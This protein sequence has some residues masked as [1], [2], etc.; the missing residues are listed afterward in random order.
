[1]AP[2]NVLKERAA[3]R[4]KE[5][6]EENLAVSKLFKHIHTGGAFTPRM[7]KKLSETDQASLDLR[8]KI[9]KLRNLLYK[10]V[11]LRDATERT[12]ALDGDPE[13]VARRVLERHFPGRVV[14]VY[15]ESEVREVNNYEDDPSMFYVTKKFKPRIFYK[16]LVAQLTV[17]FCLDD[18]TFANTHK[19]TF[20]GAVGIEEL[21]PDLPSNYWHVRALAT[22]NLIKRNCDPRPL[23]INADHVRQLLF[24]LL[25]AFMVPEKAIG[26]FMIKWRH[27]GV[28]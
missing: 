15:A 5:R 3:V 4:R 23:V 20:D 14:T 6:A 2:P 28:V 18:E 21:G 1:M 26:E 22:E 7:F 27:H 17:E 9:Y 11:E 8:D 19:I 16:M 24:D 10:V 12:L 13:D 25:E